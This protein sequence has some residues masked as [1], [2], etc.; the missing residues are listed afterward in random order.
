MHEHDS[1]ATEPAPGIDERG[2]HTV[3]EPSATVAEPVTASAT[4]AAPGHF[5]T[6]PAG[7]GAVNGNG[8]FHAATG[9]NGHTGSATGPA[10][11][12]NGWA[13]AP[14]G[15]G[16]PP[17]PG[18][19]WGQADPNGYPQYHQT[20]VPGY[21]PPI[22]GPPPVPPTAAQQPE[23][24]RGQRG[25]IIALAGLIAALLV[26]AGVA[27]IM[28]VSGGDK[29][30]HA[31]RANAATA[32]PRTVTTIIRERTIQATPRP[33]RRRSTSSRS[34]KRT[35]SNANSGRSASVAGTSS[36]T[37]ARAEIKSMLQRH[38]ANIRDGNYSTA[39]ADL[40]ASLGQSQSSWTS[41]IRA[42][43]LYSF[44]LSVA[45]EITSSSSAVANIVTFHTEADASGCK[46]WSGSWN[47]A[48]SG[49]RW[50]I[51]KSNLSPTVVSCGG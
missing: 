4:Q 39:F 27:V 20:P 7:Q 10:P 21:G 25:L 26:G 15:S 24:R 29:T 11:V 43:G 40:G 28:V 51:T 44:D 34:R 33:N 38:F 49:G 41:D 48:K 14:H 22:Y 42:D 47:L 37:L 5:D 46:D 32:A 19:A 50:L 9:G 16:M 30:A 31:A 23:N 1:A 8:S 17:Q 2:Q 13:T 18:P 3:A 35:S 12:A 45:P 6:A 36:P